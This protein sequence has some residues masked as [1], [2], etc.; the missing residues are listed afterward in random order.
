MQSSAQIPGHSPCGLVFLPDRED[1]GCLVDPARHQGER[2][3][4][5]HSKALQIR[6]CWGRQG[7]QGYKMGHEPLEQSP[8]FRIQG[9]RLRTEHLWTGITHVYP[10]GSF[11]PASS[12]TWWRQITSPS[13]ENGNIPVM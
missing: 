5:H 10:Q 9:E 3:K 7:H 13:L 4:C 2:K 8:W 12:S 11:C 6:L 1:P